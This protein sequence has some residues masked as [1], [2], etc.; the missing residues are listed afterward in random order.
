[1]RVFLKKKKLATVLANN[2]LPVYAFR[3]CLTYLVGG[4]QALQSLF[5]IKKIY[6][7]VVKYFFPS[8]QTCI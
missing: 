6:N 2:S 7:K 1:M 8:S 5:V 4:E 3:D